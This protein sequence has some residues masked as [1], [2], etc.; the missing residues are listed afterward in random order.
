VLEEAFRT[1]IGL[2]EQILGRDL[3]AKWLRR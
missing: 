1:D 2:L 3:G